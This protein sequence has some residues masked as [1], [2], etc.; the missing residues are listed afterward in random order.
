MWWMMITQ[1]DQFGKPIPA[2]RNSIIND[3]VQAGQ[4][5][6]LET[7][8]AMGLAIPP[9]HHGQAWKKLYA[10]IALLKD[11]VPLLCTKL[12]NGRH[13]FPN[14]AF[15]LRLGIARWPDMEMIRYSCESTV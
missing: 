2:S 4:D 11:K 15:V 12:L 5:K 10:N 9:R 6:L 3:I 1:K 7:V 13:F 8:K 14:P